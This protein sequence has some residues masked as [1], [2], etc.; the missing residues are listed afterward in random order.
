[1]YIGGGYT[2][3][4]REKPEKLPRKY[5]KL[6]NY[7][8]YDER[9]FNGMVK[10]GTETNTYLM[11]MQNH[12]MFFHTN[13]SKRHHIKLLQDWKKN[14]RWKYKDFIHQPCPRNRHEV[15]T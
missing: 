10:F 1:M 5:N 4:F 2:L 12:S 7:L 3:V 13:I 11:T 6:F 9:Y 14:S 15:M 8:S